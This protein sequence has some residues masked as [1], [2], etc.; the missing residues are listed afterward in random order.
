M[1]VLTYD[2]PLACSD[3]PAHLMKNA[4][5]LLKDEYWKLD[6][7]RAI[8]MA[9]EWTTDGSFFHTTINADGSKTV[10]FDFVRF[11]SF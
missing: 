3:N 8:K 11:R 5:K 9:K 6:D 4:K 1:Y 7:E 10:R 2:R